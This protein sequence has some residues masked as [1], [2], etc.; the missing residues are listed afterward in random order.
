M[1]NESWTF[2][3]TEWSM[4]NTKGKLNGIVI[5]KNIVYFISIKLIA[6][7]TAD[8]VELSICDAKNF[9]LTSWILMR[10]AI[11]NSTYSL[12]GLFNANATGNIKA[13]IHLKS[14]SSFSLIKGSHITLVPIGKGSDV[15]GLIASLGATQ[16]IRSS[17]MSKLLPREIRFSNGLKLMEDTV[18]IKRSGIYLI[19]VDIS[20]SLHGR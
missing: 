8:A 10:H 2:P 1:I 4:V 14:E 13:S 11:S 12:S 16:K 15:T 18:I 7:F 5:K 9:T 3:V 17:S 19:T 6:E 20:V